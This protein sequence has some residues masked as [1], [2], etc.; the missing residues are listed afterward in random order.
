MG[1]YDRDYGRSYDTGSGWRDGG[2]Q[3]GATLPTSANGRLLLLL[4]VVYLAQWLLNGID[5]TDRLVL[6]ADWPVR[7]WTLYGLVTYGF[8]HSPG[9]VF[10]LLFN[11]LALFF[12]GRAI[13]A[14]LGGREYITFFVAAVVFSGMVWS[15][16]EN[17]SGFDPKQP[18]VLLGASGGIAGVILLYALWYPHVQVQLMGILPVPAWLMAVIFLATDIQGA[19]QRSGNVA[20][21]AHLGGAL[22]G[23]LY[24]K[25]GWRLS[26]WAP[27]LSSGSSA[28]RGG[29][30][31]IKSLLKRKPKLRVHCDDEDAGR[32][33]PED[34]V[35]EILRKIQ[36]HGQSSLT[37]EERRVLERASRRYKNRRG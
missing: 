6:P 25:S 32:D 8:I 14:R 19:L 35:D 15:L 33:S 18:P 10:H 3:G 23:F 11:G 28:D 12:F 31:G 36:E 22:F 13:E 9:N 27:A 24:F 7:P 4:G 26:D 20:Y 2:G 1:L 16:A 34:R 29:A 5:L 17:A 37:A 30:G 21:T